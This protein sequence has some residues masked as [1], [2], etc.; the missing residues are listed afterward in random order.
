VLSRATVLDTIATAVLYLLSL[1]V[2]FGVVPT[3]SRG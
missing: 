1:T 3:S 2:V